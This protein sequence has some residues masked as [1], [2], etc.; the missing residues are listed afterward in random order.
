MGCNIWAANLK[1]HL[2]IKNG[3]GHSQ[4]CNSG[5]VSERWVAIKEKKLPERTRQSGQPTV[6]KRPSAKRDTMQGQRWPI[7]SWEFYFSLVDGSGQ[8]PGKPYSRTIHAQTIRLKI[9]VVFQGSK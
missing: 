3:S 8:P 4:R 7:I 9:R 6:Q 1:F 2:K 5:M